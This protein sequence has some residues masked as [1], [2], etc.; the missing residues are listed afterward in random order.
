MNFSLA[1]EQELLRDALRRFVEK[2]YT[3]ERRR[4]AIANEPGWSREA[5]GRLAE[6]GV[7]GLLV[8]QGLG[9]YGGS[10][11]DAAVAMETLGEGLLVEPFAA[12][13]ILGASAI[14]CGGT[15]AQQ[16]ELLPAV[17]SGDTVLAFGHGEGG[18]S[19][20]AGPLEPTATAAAGAYVLDGRKSLVLH[21]AQA[22]ILVVSA[23]L[24]AQ[25]REPEPALFLVP[26][27]TPGLTRR[28]HP[29]IDGLRA[30]DVLLNAV[31]VPASARLGPV[32]DTSAVIGQVLDRGAAA[33]CAEAVGV[34]QQLH[35]QTLD[36]IKTRQQFGQPISRFQ[37]L[38]HRAVDIYIALE[39][40]RSMAY[41]AAMAAD[42]ADADQRRAGVSAAKAYIGRCGRWLAQAA[43]QMH[44]GIGLT[45]ELPASHYAKR[46]TML[47]FW[48]GTRDE[49]LQRFISHSCRS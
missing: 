6:L 46:L 44:G 27:R 33:A 45:D 15:A 26:A 19:I 30:A 1:E 25:A 37:V 8:P 34:M 36:Y 14:V 7:L 38:Q 21:G 28:D 20:A 13:A 41:F 42:S 31:K 2:D 49:H 24:R 9:G 43:L 39:H 47:D 22:D 10:M 48:F 4:A 12:S 11:V 3:F 32:A 5:W 23:T 29:T 35:R 17:M 40:C 16:A 18:S